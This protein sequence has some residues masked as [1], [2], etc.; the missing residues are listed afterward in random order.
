MADK[1]SVP[2]AHL[3]AIGEVAVRWNVVETCMNM[4]LIEL[5][6]LEYWQLTSHVPFIHMAFNQKLDVMSSLLKERKFHSDESILSDYKSRID[7]LLRDGQSRRNKILH[8]TWSGRSKEVTYQSFK[9]RGTV[10]IIESMGSLHFLEESIQAI[11]SCSD[12]LMDFLVKLKTSKP[13]PQRG[14]K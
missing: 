8:S 11:C 2:D 14:Q 1:Q 6:S 12:T 3:R 9:A 7:P 5:M 13:I 4:V 10:E